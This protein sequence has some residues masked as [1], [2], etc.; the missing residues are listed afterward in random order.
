MS[1]SIKLLFNQLFKKLNE[2]VLF[3]LPVDVHAMALN[4]C[5]YNFHVNNTLS[6][7]L[8]QESTKG[9]FIFAR[10]IFVN[11]MITAKQMAMT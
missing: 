7:L 3:Q 10:F 9:K 11:Q 2:I 5:P 1:Y 6:G 8:E 4:V